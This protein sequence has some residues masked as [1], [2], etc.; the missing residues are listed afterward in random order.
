MCG[1]TTGVTAGSAGAAMFCADA[2]TVG[3]GE[4]DAAGA[5]VIVGAGGET[6]AGDGE[7]AGVGAGLA[8]AVEALAVAV[9]DAT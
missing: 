9:V 4:G 3:T 1:F 5:G 6:T 8:G 2:I 7:R